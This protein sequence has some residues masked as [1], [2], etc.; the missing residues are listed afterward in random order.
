MKSPVESGVAQKSPAATT[1]FQGNGGNNTGNGN[2]GSGN[3][4]DNSG[5][6][7]TNNGG[8]W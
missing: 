7:N 1:L 4:G 8:R 3:S 2:S 6:G 5:N